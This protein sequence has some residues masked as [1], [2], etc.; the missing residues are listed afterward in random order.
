[1]TTRVE[2]A[3]SSDRLRAAFAGFRVMKR[4]QLPRLQY[5]WAVI[6][7]AGFTRRPESRLTPLHA[8]HSDAAIL[9]LWAELPPQQWVKAGE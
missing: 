8:T 9:P 4:R 3:G 2:A 7:P 1:M 5:C 6:H